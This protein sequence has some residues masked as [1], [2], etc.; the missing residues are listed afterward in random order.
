M[1]KRFFGRFKFWILKQHND[2]YVEYFGF[3]FGL[4]KDNNHTISKYIVGNIY[5][6]CK[7]LALRIG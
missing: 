6:G 5:Y 7:H 2:K 4:T 3:D 1:S